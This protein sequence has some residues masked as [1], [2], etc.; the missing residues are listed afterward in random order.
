MH[1]VRENEKLTG[2]GAHAEC[3]HTHTRTHRHTAWRL[4][5]VLPGDQCHGQQPRLL[6][7]LHRRRDHSSGCTRHASQRAEAPSTP[8]CRRWI[9]RRWPPRRKGQRQRRRAYCW[10]R[11]WHVA[12]EEVKK[13]EGAPWGRGPSFFWPQ[14]SLGRIGT[15]LATQSSITTHVRH[16]GRW[17]RPEPQGR[18]GRIAMRRADGM[19]G[20]EP[21]WELKPP[22]PMSSCAC[23]PPPR[24]RRE[25]TDWVPSPHS[26]CPWL[27]AL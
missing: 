2:T 11:P 20:N 19:Y 1:R 26:R 24:D 7:W 21:A 5:R 14:T 16:A 17:S 23:Q 3:T 15:W 22:F 9:R 6:E 13:R 27:D 12:V 25:K 10:V 18:A 8:G 4:P